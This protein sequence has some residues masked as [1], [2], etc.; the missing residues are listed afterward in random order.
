MCQ[1]YKGCSFGYGLAEI[2]R[3]R[4]S[5]H[6]SKSAPKMMHTHN[7]PKMLACSFDEFCKGNVILEIL[8]FTRLNKLN[9]FRNGFP[10]NHKPFSGFNWLSKAILNSDDKPRIVKYTL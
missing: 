3:V 5:R 1:S 8:Y 7:L 6:A 9:C 2:G 10:R 4:P